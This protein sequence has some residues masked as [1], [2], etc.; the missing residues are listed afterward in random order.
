MKCKIWLKIENEEDEEQ[1]NVSQDLSKRLLN[2]ILVLIL[3]K[4]VIF[5]KLEQWQL[6][7]ELIV[8]IAMLPSE[9]LNFYI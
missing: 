3:S 6:K 2:D 5:V 7:C 1:K 8:V 4:W 9:M